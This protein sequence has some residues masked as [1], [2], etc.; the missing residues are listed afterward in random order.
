[1]FSHKKKSDSMDYMEAEIEQIEENEKM[2]KIR[3]SF[4]KLNLIS[5]KMWK[6]GKT[7]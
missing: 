2:W 4:K 3:K 7:I 5:K 1:M 6:T